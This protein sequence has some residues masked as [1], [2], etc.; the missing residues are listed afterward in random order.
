L[1]ALAAHKNY[2]VDFVASGGRVE[3]FIGWFFPEGN[4]GERHGCD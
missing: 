1:D 4:S 3:L 2:L